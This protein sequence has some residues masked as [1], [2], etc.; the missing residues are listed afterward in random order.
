MIHGPAIGICV[1][2]T[3]DYTTRLICVT[4]PVINSPRFSSQRRFEYGLL[5]TQAEIL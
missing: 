1:N 4:N 2:L 3:S 5:T